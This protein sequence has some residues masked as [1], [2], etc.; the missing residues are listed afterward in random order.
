MIFIENNKTDA[1]LHF[2]LEELFARYIKS[3]EPVFMLWQTEKTVMLGNNQFVKAEVDVAFSKEKNI[4]IVRRSSGG[5]AIYTDPGTFLYSVIEPFIN[6]P[7]VHRERVADNIV[8]ALN[9]LGVSAVREGRNDIL[10]NG[11]KISGFA[12]YTAGTHICTHGSLLYDADLETLAKVLIANESKLHPK[13]IT[14]IRSRVTNIKPYLGDLTVKEFA[15]LLKK[16][17]CADVDI[18]GYDFSD[19]DLKKIS[20]IYDEKYS[21]KK[22]TFKL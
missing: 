9:S 4:S 5:G 20:L 6:D 2:S 1:M 13:G 15:V 17:L 12:Q 7:K 22:W 16:E 3:N 18:T 14:S 11:K 19:D 21:N 10:V 8:K